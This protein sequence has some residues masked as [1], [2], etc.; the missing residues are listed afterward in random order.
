MEVISLWLVC[1]LWHPYLLLELQV[2]EAMESIME[3]LRKIFAGK[4]QLLKVELLFAR[5]DAYQWV[6]HS[7]LFSLLMRL[8]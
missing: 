1:V 4:A 7:L 5:H 6:Q 8:L 2:Y 3:V